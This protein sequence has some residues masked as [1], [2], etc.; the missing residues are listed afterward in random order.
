MV[1]GQQ[2]LTTFNMLLQSFVDFIKGLP[3]NIDKG[4]DAMHITD[5]LTLA[6]VRS[7]DLYKIKP[8]GDKFRTYKFGYSADNPSYDYLRFRILK[9]WLRC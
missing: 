1:D 8:T 2:L 6:D 7:D 4:D 9:E 3:E 5:T